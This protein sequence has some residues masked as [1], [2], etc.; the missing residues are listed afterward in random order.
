MLVLSCMGSGFGVFPIMCFT[1]SGL[2]FGQRSELRCHW[3]DR[4]DHDDDDRQQLQQSSSMM[5]HRSH[6]NGPAAN[7]ILKPCKALRAK[8]PSS[9]PN[10]SIHRR[11]TLLELSSRKVCLLVMLCRFED[12][13]LHRFS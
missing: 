12:S 1:D 9:I 13:R 5:M 2:N 4:H 8:Q 6:N 3:A 7:Y 10:L 11:Q